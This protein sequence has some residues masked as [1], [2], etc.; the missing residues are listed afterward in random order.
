MLNRPTRRNKSSKDKVN[1]TGSASLDDGDP[2]SMEEL[3]Q[4]GATD[5]F[6]HFVNHIE[7]SRLGPSS[8][9][10][11][12]LPCK[13]L[14]KLIIVYAHA[15]ARGRNPRPWLGKSP[16]E[17]PR[18]A[19]Y[20]LLRVLRTLSIDGPMDVLG[21][22]CGLT[23]CCRGGG[24]VDRPQGHEVQPVGRGYARNHRNPY[25]IIAAPGQINSTVPSTRP[26]IGGPPQQPF[27]NEGSHTRGGYN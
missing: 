13:E 15:K 7:R 2:V 9:L 16:H 11:R 4:N 17:S 20:R 18:E 25:R 3:S 22:G 24:Y 12:V 14:I 6:I 1:K 5:G 19:V 26:S 27:A 8:P 21:N 10:P 23:H